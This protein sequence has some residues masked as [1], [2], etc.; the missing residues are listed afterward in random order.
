M[1]TH[2]D[3]RDKELQKLLLETLD[4]FGP[5]NENFIHQIVAICH[6]LGRIDAGQIRISQN[7]VY[8]LKW[9]SNIADLK[10]EGLVMVKQKAYMQYFLVKKSTSS[11]KYQDI[12]SE[13]RKINKVKRRKLALCLHSKSIENGGGALKITP[14]EL[15]KLL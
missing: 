9:E 6:Y 13:L 8:S 4:T 1:Q 14:K 11:K 7:D 15:K 10:E 12:L 5:L 3:Y 2:V